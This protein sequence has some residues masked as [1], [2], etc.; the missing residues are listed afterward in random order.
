[1]KQEISN[2][3]STE[4]SQVSR[5]TGLPRFVPAAATAA[6]L[7]TSMSQLLTLSHPRIQFYRRM[8]LFLTVALV[9]IVLSA[10]TSAPQAHASGGGCWSY[11]TW[12]SNATYH[13]SQDPILYRNNDG[14]PK[15]GLGLNSC[16]QYI[17]IKWS[18]EC[19]I[20]GCSNSTYYQ[21]DW[22]R[23]GLNDWQVF[24]VPSG[25]A[26]YGYMYSNFNNAHLG[27]YYDFAVTKCTPS[28]GCGNWSPTVRITT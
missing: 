4:G 5:R 3:I 23:P 9:L 13:E 1:M 18:P 24:T 27:T 12:S 17:R 15:L 20:E 8:G 14:G 19:S 28:Y 21:I 7:G 6:V 2:A 11:N 25:Q 22:R 16:G 10:F 26:Y